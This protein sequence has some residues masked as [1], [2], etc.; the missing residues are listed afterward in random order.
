MVPL[1]EETEHSSQ[2]MQSRNDNILDKK[3]NFYF[4]TVFSLL[5]DVFIFSR[6][7]LSFMSNTTNGL[8]LSYQN[9]SLMKAE[10][11]NGTRESPHTAVWYIYILSLSL[12]LKRPMKWSMKNFGLAFA[13]RLKRHAPW[14]YIQCLG[15]R[16]FQS[17]VCGPVVVLG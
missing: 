16:H 10:D 14:I 11:E 6:W 12:R 17:V 7:L 8:L 3:F 9:V 4:G 2:C 5:L 15:L 13:W 1:K